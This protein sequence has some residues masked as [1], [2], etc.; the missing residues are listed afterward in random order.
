MTA[1]RCAPR[2]AASPTPNCSAP[3]SAS[4]CSRLIHAAALSVGVGGA[5]AAEVDR[6]GLMAATRAAMQR[7]MAMLNPQP[8][9]LL[10]DAVDLRELVPLPQQALVAAS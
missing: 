3:A 9:A 6:D 5:S 8:E 10:V 4:A 7:A 2:C 1:A